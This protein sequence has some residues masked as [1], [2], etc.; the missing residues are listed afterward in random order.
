MWWRVKSPFDLEF[1]VLVVGGRVA[2]CSKASAFPFHGMLIG[3]AWRDV[4]KRLEFAQF[5]C[6]MESP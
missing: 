2:T 3:D 1:L 5:T 4:R 6:V